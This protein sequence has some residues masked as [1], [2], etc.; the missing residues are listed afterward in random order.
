MRDQHFV[1]WWVP[2]GH[3]PSMEEALE[4]LDHLRSHGESDHA[5]GCTHV[6]TAGLWQ[7]TTCTGYAAE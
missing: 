1:M 6:K 5:F 2:A 3:R 7:G 4:R